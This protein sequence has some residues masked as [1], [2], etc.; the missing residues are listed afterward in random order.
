MLH[1]GVHTTGLHP[2]Y[3]LTSFRDLYW[4]STRKLSSV[5][6]I[7]GYQF[8]LRTFLLRIFCY[9]ENLSVKMDTFP[10]RD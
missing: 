5:V 2:Y 7:H 8:M 10:I 3:V 4:Y 9:A 1:Q 6:P